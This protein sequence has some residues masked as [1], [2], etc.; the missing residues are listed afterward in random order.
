MIN[1]LRSRSV[2]ALVA[3]AS[4]LLAVAACSSG[5]GSASGPNDSPAPAGADGADGGSTT[6]VPTTAATTTTTTPPP[7]LPGGGR[8]I[9][10]EHRV[11]AYYGNSQSAAMGVLGETGPEEAV[12]RLAEASA[13]FA[14]PDRPVLGAFELIVS[15]AQ[16]SPGDDGDY[17]VPTPP[18]QIQQWLDV[19]RANDLLLLLDVQ[20]GR[21]SFVDA[22]KPL[23]NF[24]R[25]PDVGL[26]LDPE[27][28]MGPG[29][30]P[31]Q[32]IGSVDVAEVNEVSAWLSDIV[33]AENL[34]E[35]L[36]VVHQFQDGMI[37]NRPA[38]EAREGLATALH[39]DGF[40]T[41]AQKIEKYTALAA[42]APF[43]NGLK[44]FYDEDIDMFTPAEALALEPS[45]DLITYQ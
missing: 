6:A 40:G 25:Q 14:D 21:A 38:L 15:V 23:E 26:A 31:G 27:W 41:Q 11:V 39:I 2:V 43:E 5:D 10:P 42:K 4:L 17:S 19:A 28:R 22:V 37:I 35:K 8:S 30:V 7:E 45:P 12:G 36:F 33:K 13:P 16:P 1:S 44:L 18:E 29:E 32:T 9:F 24:L 20:P 34:P 3:T